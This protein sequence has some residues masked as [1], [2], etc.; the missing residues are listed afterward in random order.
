MLKNRPVPALEYG[1]APNQRTCIR[2]FE[3]AGSDGEIKDV[4]PRAQTLG[5][6][7]HAGP[8]VPGRLRASAAATEV[9]KFP[10]LRSPSMK[11]SSW[12]ESATTFADAVRLELHFQ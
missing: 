11:S 1:G 12:R 8:T 4:Y 6:A 7:V 2:P 3:A 5:P 9:F 10:A